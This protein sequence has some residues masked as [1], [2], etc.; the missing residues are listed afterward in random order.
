M[1]QKT[2]LLNIQ[3]D[4]V[5]KLNYLDWNPYQEFNGAIQAYNIY[6]GI[7][8]VFGIN[9]IATLGPQEHTYTDDVNEIT[10]QGGICYY[11]EVIEAMNIYNSSEKSISNVQCIILP[12][13]IFIP[14]AFRPDGFNTV[15]RPVIS[16]FDY[17][18]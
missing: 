14:N 4:E 7:D 13:I 1:R 3:N 11:I 17:T 15:F 9:P 12:P 10:S 2:I 16:D 18:S 5:L 8:S 6:R